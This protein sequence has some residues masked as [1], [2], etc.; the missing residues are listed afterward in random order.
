MCGR[1]P[2]WIIVSV[3]RLELL[4]AKST[5]VRVE[6]WLFDRHSSLL[7]TSWALLKLTWLPLRSSWKQLLRLN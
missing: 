5:W 2:V 7:V 3:G 4:L 6:S 1:L